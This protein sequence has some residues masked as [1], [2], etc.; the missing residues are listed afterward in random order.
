MSENKNKNIEKLR[1]TPKAVKLLDSII[2]E[3]SD[4]NESIK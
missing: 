2:Y 1:P 4:G 3:V